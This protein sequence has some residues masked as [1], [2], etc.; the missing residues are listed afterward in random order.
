MQRLLP[1]DHPVMRGSAVQ[2][3]QQGGGVGD[4]GALAH[5]AAGQLPQS[6]SIDQFDGFLLAGGEGPAGGVLPAESAG[7]PDRWPRRST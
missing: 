3:A 7:W 4:E 5:T 6:R 1:G 2:L